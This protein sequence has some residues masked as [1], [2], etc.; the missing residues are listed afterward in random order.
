MLASLRELKNSDVP[1]SFEISYANRS[2]HT[3]QAEGYREY[4]AWVG[5]I[6]QAIEKRLIGATSASLP[7]PSSLFSTTTSHAAT[8]QAANALKNR[9]LNA[10]LVRAVL[11]KSTFCAECDKADPDWV[12]VN[13]GCLMCIDC[14]GIHR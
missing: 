1:F 2:S 6:R 3:L 8:T 7:P 9:Q 13:L 5:A 12:S 14:S 4:E 10:G 11:E